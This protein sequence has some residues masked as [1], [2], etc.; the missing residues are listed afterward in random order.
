MSTGVLIRQ[1]Q[2]MISTV[3]SNLT[4]SHLKEHSESMK[5]RLCQ[6]YLRQFSCGF[7]LLRGRGGGEQCIVGSVTA[8]HSGRFQLKF[9]V[10][11]LEIFK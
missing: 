8:P 3:A 2:T 5:L 6:T 9:S 10:G 4:T 7:I 1:F 11:F